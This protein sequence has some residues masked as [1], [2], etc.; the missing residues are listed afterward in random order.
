M[1]SEA[2]EQGALSQA[3]QIIEKFGGI[4]PM[5]GKMLV[6][7]TTVQGWKKRGVIPANRREDV[8]RAAELNNIDLTG[9]TEAAA[10]AAAVDNVKEFVPVDLEKT[11]AEMTARQEPPAN[12]SSVRDSSAS[13]PHALS[14]VPP[15]VASAPAA[16]QDVESRIAA[17]E[18]RAVRKGALM[19]ALFAALVGGAGFMLA[20]P[21]AEQGAQRL[22]AAQD[23]LTALE[24]KVS[25]DPA[26]GGAA[27]AAVPEN[28]TQQMTALQNQ[29]AELQG[30]IQ[31]LQASSATGKD[32]ESIERRLAALEGKAVA[33]SAD[34]AGLPALFEKLRQMQRTPDGQQMLTS[35]A[36]NLNATLAGQENAPDAALT[37]VQQQPGMLSEA[38][39]GLSSQDLK[40]AAF[41][42]AIAQLNSSLSRSAPFDEDLQLI[43]K[44]TG[45]QAGAEPKASIDQ[46]MA[47]A[48]QGV[49]TPDGLK[50]QFMAVG[51]EIVAASL[52]TKD[53]TLKDKALAQLNELIQVRRKGQL[54]T[55]TDVQ[56]IVARVQGQLD[57]GNLSSALSEL[58]TLQGPAAEKAKSFTESVRSSMQA[59]ALKA[60][61]ASKTVESLGNGA[62]AGLQAVLPRLDDLTP[63]PVVQA[64][65]PDMAAPVTAAAKPAP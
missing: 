42:I 62:S 44:L 36:R 24:K 16:T 8:L 18:K 19:A 61:I 22:E 52:D 48:R 28:V 20:M 46:A 21:V 50:S 17:A 9:L 12:D 4:R 57:Q 3:E 34:S 6:P 56:A 63:Q 40:P 47:S 32:G 7:V 59:Q 1:M 39:K 27:T 55:G 2:S 37:A 41:L 25:G 26:S 29:V 58:E 43:Q 15:S 5:A 35:L 11:M 51:P 30:L 23:R 10:E 53:A 38:L 49:M 13:F 45:S 64:P 60:T 54:I 65:A 33:P 31:Q 14:S